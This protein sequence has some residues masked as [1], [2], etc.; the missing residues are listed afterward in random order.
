MLKEWDDMKEKEKRRESCE[1]CFAVHIH[2]HQH[3][4]F[5]LEDHITKLT[6][7]SEFF[8]SVIGGN[9]KKG[10]EEEP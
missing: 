1:M 10:G 3:K 4:S 9:N 5:T 2:T 8:A 7:Y 6:R